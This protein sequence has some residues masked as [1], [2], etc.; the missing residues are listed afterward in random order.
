LPGLLPA[1][2]MM[3]RGAE[4]DVQGAADSIQVFDRLKHHLDPERFAVSAWCGYG[5]L[6]T[7]WLALRP[8]SG[9]DFASRFFFRFVVWWLLIAADGAAVGFGP[10]WAGLMKYYPFRLVDVMLPI[11]VAVAVA[12]EV[13]RW[14]ALPN[15]GAE[16]HRRAI[17]RHCIA[18]GA[19]V[20]A[21]FSPLQP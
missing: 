21:M 15:D 12:G 19:L 1:L 17:A 10:R 6:L 16:L 8:W 18:V 2:A 5:A 4:S 11:G 20:W 14:S 7:L 3:Y 13:F 9:R